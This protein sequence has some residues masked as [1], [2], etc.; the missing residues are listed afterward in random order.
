MV[1]KAHWLLIVENVVLK[2]ITVMLQLQT[3]HGENVFVAGQHL[4]DESFE[5]D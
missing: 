1:K 3:C 2:L 5:P 4:S